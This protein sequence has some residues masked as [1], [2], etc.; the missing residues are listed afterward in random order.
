MSHSL[1]SRKTLT[2]P[3]SLMSIDQHSAKQLVFASLQGT[4][5]AYIFPR[6]LRDFLAFPCTNSVTDASVGQINPTWISFR[7][8]F[9]AFTCTSVRSKCSLCRPE[10]DPFSP[11]T[12]QI[13]TPLSHYSNCIDVDGTPLQ[14]PVCILCQTNVY[15]PPPKNLFVRNCAWNIA[16]E[17]FHL[18][19]LLEF[20]PLRAR[21]L[22]HKNI[23]NA[24]I[25]RGFG[26]GAGSHCK[27]CLVLTCT[28][29][30]HKSGRGW[31]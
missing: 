20:S 31:K 5:Q 25:N 28:S 13:R 27:H 14:E 21:I 2:A 17:R 16:P 10:Q 18:V 8:I 29:G 1:L 23:Q 19:H 26:G 11:Q 24:G 30:I 22:Q 12:R 3:P 15:G 4:P 6:I 7:S 9:A